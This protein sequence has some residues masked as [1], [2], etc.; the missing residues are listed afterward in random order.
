MYNWHDGN[1][2]NLRTIKAQLIVQKLKNNEARSKFTGSYKK[3][4]CRWN[5]KLNAFIKKHVR[6]F[7]SF[8]KVNQLPKPEMTAQINVFKGGKPNRSRG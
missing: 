7:Q 3:N 8:S 2:N 4:A 1:K 6:S 5:V